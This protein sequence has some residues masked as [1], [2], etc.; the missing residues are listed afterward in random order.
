MTVTD[1]YG[2]KL[3]CALVGFEANEGD[4]LTFTEERNV[5]ISRVIIM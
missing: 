3:L 5:L 4:V 1:S 2:F